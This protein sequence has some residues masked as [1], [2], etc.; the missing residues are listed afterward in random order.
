MELP[1]NMLAMLTA[2]H[3]LALW[4]VPPA[5]RHPDADRFLP[6]RPAQADELITNNIR[7]NPT[8]TRSPI[9]KAASWRGAF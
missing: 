6:A 8:R 7:S 3:R 2:H 9:S 1:I 5:S 4:L